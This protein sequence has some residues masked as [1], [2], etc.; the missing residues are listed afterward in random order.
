MTDRNLGAGRPFDADE[1]GDADSGELRDA[2]QTGRTL[3]RSIDDVPTRVS[4]D[5]TGRV[6]AAIADEPAPG[7][8]G[9]M[10]PFRR[11]GL[12]A[13][14]G[15]SVRQA[16]STLTAPGLP[17]FARATALAYVLVVALAGVALAGAA[18]I[19]VGSALGLFDARPSPTPTITELPPPVPT[20]APPTVPSATGD[21]DT[22]EPFESPEAS[23][24]H[25]GAGETG[26]PG[27][28]GGGGN[29]GPG[30]SS[31][32]SGGGSDGGD[33]GG[34]SGPGSSDSG[35]DDGS[36]SDSGSSS[37]NTPRPTDTPRPTGTPKPS[38]T[39]H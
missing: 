10:A 19:S 8:V 29:S 16:W 6:M 23:D 38:E 17:S 5:F 26:E 7:A 33:D 37:T 1:L 13:G 27:D 15:T 34:N 32:G 36:G 25:G 35:S 30:S 39:P 11:R 18:T 3:E 2:L 28:D 4:G 12:L 24:D 14:F 9:F 21:L 20:L 22:D 31:S